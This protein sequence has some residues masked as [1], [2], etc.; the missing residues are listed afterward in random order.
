MT[1]KRRLGLGAFELSEKEWTL[2]RQLCDILKVCHMSQS[3]TWSHLS[4]TTDLEA[5]YTLFLRGT[6]NLA[7]VIPAMDHIDTVFTN[8]IINSQLLDPAIHTALHL[9]KKTLNRYYS[10]TDKSETYRIAMGMF[11]F[12]V[13]TTNLLT[14]L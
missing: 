8:G 12:H 4:T 5:H 9:A 10:L 7:M 11:F 14:L 13:C 6:P 2:A 3:C 1:D